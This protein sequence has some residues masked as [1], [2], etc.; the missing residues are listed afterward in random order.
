MTKGSQITAAEKSLGYALSPAV[1]ECFARYQIGWD[2][3]LVVLGEPGQVEPVRIPASWAGRIADVLTGE[4]G[5]KML[6]KVRSTLRALS[7]DQIC[8]KPSQ[9]WRALEVTPW[10]KVR[11]VIIGQDPYHTLS[12]GD[13][14]ATGLAFEARHGA[15]V[16]PS[17]TRIFAEVREDLRV[18]SSDRIQISS[19]ARDLT[20]V[21]PALPPLPSRA[22]SPSPRLMR[23]CGEKKRARSGGRKRQGRI[24]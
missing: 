3:Q 18:R 16:P 5:A 12:F 23:Y 11:V 13:P 6:A 21:W 17:L 8:P 7:P 15:P 1:R 14:V 2:G 24:E 9:V 22:P 19:W 4:E 20:Q 10:S